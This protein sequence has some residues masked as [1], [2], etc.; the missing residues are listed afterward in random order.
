MKA[1]HPK[2]PQRFFPVIL[3]DDDVR[4]VHDA[5]LNAG[6]K[7]LAAML[8]RKARRTKL[9]RMYTDAIRYHDENEYDLDDNPI[10]SRGDDGAYV[11]LWC[12]VSEDD[13]PSATS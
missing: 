1:K 5:L 3:Y 8:R 6:N 2:E 13:L 7:K 9:D 4:A 10:V 12:W 11:M